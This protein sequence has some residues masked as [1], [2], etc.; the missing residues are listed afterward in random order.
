MILLLSFHTFDKSLLVID[1][2]CMPA[3]DPGAQPTKH[4][5]PNN[6]TT[7]QSI[8]SSLHPF[9]LGYAV[10]EA[11]KAVGFV[12]FPLQFCFTLRRAIIVIDGKPPLSL[13]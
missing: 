8:A 9:V 5:N 13:R 6:N 10:F 12:P 11:I 7:F 4:E 1:A 2:S 3:R